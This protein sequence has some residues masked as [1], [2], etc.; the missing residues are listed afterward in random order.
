MHV[1]SRKYFFW[2]KNAFHIPI[3]VIRENFTNK[4]HTISIDYDIISVVHLNKNNNTFE[5]ELFIRVCTI[6]LLSSS[7]ICIFT[8]FIM[9]VPDK[10]YTVY[11]IHSYTYIMCAC[12]ITISYIGHIILCCLSIIRSFRYDAACWL[13]HKD[14]IIITIYMIICIV[15]CSILLHYTRF[16]IRRC[17]ILRMFKIDMRF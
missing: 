11:T 17:S 7:C 9:F 14:I 4:I 1:K 10:G 16:I 8:R 5:H 6:I 2:K 15:K 3:M 12:I 13:F